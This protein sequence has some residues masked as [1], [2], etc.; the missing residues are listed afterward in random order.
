MVVV[1]VADL[2]ACIIGLSVTLFLWLQP[3]ERRSYAP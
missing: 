1:S 3:C 2:L